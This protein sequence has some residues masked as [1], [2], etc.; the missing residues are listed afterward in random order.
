MQNLTALLTNR[1]RSRSPF[2]IDKHVPG[3]E[4]LLLAALAA[5][6]PAGQP[7]GWLRRG[8]F[9]VNGGVDRVDE[10]HNHDCPDQKPGGVGSGTTY[11]RKQPNAAWER[12]CAQAVHAHANAHAS[13]GKLAVI[14]LRRTTGTA[15][16]SSHMRKFR[17]SNV[18]MTRDRQ[19]QRTD[20]LAG[21][22]VVPRISYPMSSEARQTVCLRPRGR[23]PRLWSRGLTESIQDVQAHEADTRHTP[24]QVQ[25][26]ASQ[27][28]HATS[29]VSVPGPPP[30]KSQCLAST[31]SESETT[32]GAQYGE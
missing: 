25:L 32:Y 2:P 6:L 21:C 15:K 30:Q 11:C 13:G 10:L 28:Q 3:S 5:L 17:F 22:H 31:G 24:S 29:S 23:N 20:V 19:P 16:C 7:A 1:F 27:R 9:V 18:F 4:P 14:S 8:R 12:M 26:P